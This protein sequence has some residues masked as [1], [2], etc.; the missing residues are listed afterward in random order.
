LEIIN[1]EQVHDRRKESAQS[2]GGGV[3]TR[4]VK[5][6]GENGRVSGEVM[7]LLESSDVV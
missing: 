6:L 5:A 4:V 3:A 7:A 2:V 1:R